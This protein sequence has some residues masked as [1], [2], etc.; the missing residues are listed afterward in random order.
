MINSV[1]EVLVCDEWV[2]FLPFSHVGGPGH[3]I[4]RWWS[5]Q[6]NTE[7]GS[8]SQSPGLGPRS[9]SNF[10][11][12][13]VSQG[14]LVSNSFH[15]FFFFLTGPKHKLKLLFP[16]VCTNLMLICYNFHSFHSL[17][18]RL[19]VW[20]LGTMFRLW[21][22]FSENILSV[23]YSVEFSPCFALVASDSSNL[24]RIHPGVSPSNHIPSF[25]L[26]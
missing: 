17:H 22:L 26:T 18:S 14:I 25:F 12:W 11:G 8:R 24:A 5:Y 16:T 6:S 13:G 2:V 23:W 21:S 19:L 7:Y 4:W 1:Y 15:I 20:T 3:D 9:H 10:P